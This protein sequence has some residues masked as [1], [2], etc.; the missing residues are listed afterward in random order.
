MK[1]TWHVNQTLSIDLHAN[2][3]PI[4]I[5]A[6]VGYARAANEA[7][8]SDKKHDWAVLFSELNDFDFHTL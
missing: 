2:S 5:S 7:P 1:Y 8:T 3:R 6:V 4:M